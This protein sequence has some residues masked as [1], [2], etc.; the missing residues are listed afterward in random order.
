MD[1][2]EYPRRPWVAVG[3]I[4]FRGDDVLLVRR[5]RP[6]E[7]G[8]WSLPGGRQELGETVI[9]AGE[10]EVREETGITVAVTGL[11][12]VVDRID[13]DPDGR[14]R[15]HYT[16]IDLAAE[17]RAGDPVAGDDADAARWWTPADLAGL[18]LWAET[19]RVIEMARQRRVSLRDPDA[20]RT[21]LEAGPP[22]PQG[23]G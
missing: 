5:A 4:V 7:A 23:L 18:D 14:V 19:R 22:D 8:T 13:R 6:P 20:V 11:V 21:C 9:A 16:L 12:D 3:V 10:R 17:W 15:F 2:R 1:D